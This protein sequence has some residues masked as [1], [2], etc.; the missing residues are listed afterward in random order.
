MVTFCHSFDSS[1]GQ[2]SMRS[3]CWAKNPLFFLGAL[4]LVEASSHPTSPKNKT[5]T[6]NLEQV[7][8]TKEPTFC[9]FFA[10]NFGW[11]PWSF[12][13]C[14]YF[15][16]RNSYFFN[17]PQDDILQL[18][19]KARV[20]SENTNN[21][22]QDAHER[23]DFFRCNVSASM[24]SALQ[25][26]DMKD[27]EHWA[28]GMDSVEWHK[29]DW[30]FRKVAFLSSSTSRKVKLKLKIRCIQDIDILIIYIYT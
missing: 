17:K 22:P 29:W 12:W 5:T 27:A 2:E 15:P 25:S 28:Q 9:F 8:F 19:V 16:Q 11:P 18:R 30:N 20:S 1:K 14:L 24:L 26:F 13:E 23:I 7:F 10:T 3:T 6:L 21:K 4:R